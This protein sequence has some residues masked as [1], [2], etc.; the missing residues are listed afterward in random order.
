MRLRRDLRR[1]LLSR[2]RHHDDAVV[3]VALT[4]REARATA[5]AID[6]V[7]EVLKPHLFSDRPESRQV[8]TP[9]LVTVRQVLAHACERADVDMDD[10]WPARAYA[11]HTEENH[12][13]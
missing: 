4:A 2:I 1:D 5:R 7:I 9:P 11:K 8:T 13:G 3:L 10:P 12:H 6:L